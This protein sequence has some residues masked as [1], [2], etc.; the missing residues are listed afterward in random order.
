MCV[1]CAQSDVVCV[2]WKQKVKV[3]K[4]YITSLNPDMSVHWL[5]SFCTSPGSVRA[6]Q[7]LHK[8]LH[9]IWQVD[10]LTPRP[11][12]YLCNTK[13][14]VLQT[15]LTKF[16]LTYMKTYFSE[17]VLSLCGFIT[18]ELFNYK[19]VKT[20]FILLSIDLSSY[21]W[22]AAFFQYNRLSFDCKYK[23]CWVTDSIN[24]ASL[25]GT[26]IAEVTNWGQNDFK[27]TIYRRSLQI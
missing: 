4:V 17:H 6:W 21:K 15:V 27:D 7:S 23:I 3:Y 8:Q 26:E 11:W 1:F 10:V 20:H 18:V 9:S 13:V 22:H 25:I 16:T 5:N 12:W 19:L 2:W 14:T 24:T